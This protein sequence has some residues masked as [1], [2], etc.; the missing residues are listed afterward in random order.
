MATTT[1]TTTDD[2]RQS[3]ASIDAPPNKECD[4]P[5]PY[6]LLLWAILWPY[7][8]ILTV[9][10]HVPDFFGRMKKSTSPPDL[11]VLVLCSP[12]VALEFALASFFLPVLWYDYDRYLC[13]IGEKNKTLP[14][15]P[16][17]GVTHGL[18][19]WLYTRYLEHPW[20]KVDVHNPDEVL[21]QARDDPLAPK[22]ILHELPLRKGPRPRMMEGLPQRQLTQLPPH[23]E[24]DILEGMVFQGLFKGAK[25]VEVGRSLL[26]GTGAMGVRWKLDALEPRH[27]RCCRDLEQNEQEFVHQHSLDKSWHVLLAPR[28]ACEVLRTGWGERGPPQ[29][30]LGMAPAGMCFIYAPRNAEE[31]FVFMD[32]LAAACRY[33]EGDGN[34]QKV[35]GEGG[36]GKG[37]GEKEDK[38][39]NWAQ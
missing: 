13:D 21:C 38:G 6:R 12:L 15:K 1:T 33:C 23:H 16:E 39:K 9:A 5:L 31:R 4:E 20:M 24:S 22:Y 19:T 34:I 11:R 36:G 28:D 29:A 18:L 30:A 17:D 26:E 32:I 25:E 3:S 14:Q 7:F 10:R 27:R 8:L 2:N 35:G 37:K